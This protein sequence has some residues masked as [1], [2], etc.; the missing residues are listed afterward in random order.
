MTQKLGE[1]DY[2]CVILPDYNLHE[3]QKATL[4]K[5]QYFS[6]VEPDFSVDMKNIAIRERSDNY[7]LG[8]YNK[9]REYL[10]FMNDDVV[11][12]VNRYRMIVPDMHL[13]AC[14]HTADKLY[15]K[16]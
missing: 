6:Q 9:S 1:V 2:D 11:F 16:L 15:R 5:G 10:H 8:D 4:G 12:K 7:F 14:Y 3:F 13:T